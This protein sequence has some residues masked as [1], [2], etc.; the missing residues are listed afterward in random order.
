MDGFVLGEFDSC[1]PQLLQSLGSLF[2]KAH[3]SS[4]GSAFRKVCEHCN[5]NCV[6]SHESSTRKKKSREACAF[7]HVA[8][9]VWKQGN[10]P[11]YRQTSLITQ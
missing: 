4:S 11:Q 7:L 2:N 9:F 6:H 8:N 10:Y 1:L 5:T 3:R